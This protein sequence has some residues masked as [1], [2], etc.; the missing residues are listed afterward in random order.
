M[1]FKPQTSNLLSINHLQNN[2]KGQGAI[3]ETSLSWPFLSVASLIVL[4]RTNTSIG[5]KQQVTTYETK[6]GP[7]KIPQS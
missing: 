4:L 2:A 7:L 3:P 1:I 6:V 5:L